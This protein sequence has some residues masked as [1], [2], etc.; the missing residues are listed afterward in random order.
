MKLRQYLKDLK[1]LNLSQHTCTSVLVKPNLR[2][3]NSLKVHSCS[4]RLED[5]LARVHDLRSHPI[6]WYK[7]HL[8]SVIGPIVT[9]AG[10][11]LE[12]KTTLLVSSIIW[13]QFFTW[14]VL[15][16]EANVNGLQADDKFFNTDKV[17][18][19]TF[20]EEQQLRE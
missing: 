19:V 6:S 7:G 12:F 4:H 16:L 2:E 15:T 20:H 9:R 18:M 3:I 10:V 5:L 17:F 11:K 14:L 8:H 13:S 1:P